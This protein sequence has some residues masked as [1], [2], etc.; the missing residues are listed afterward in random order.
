LF[1]A[2]DYSKDCGVHI[3]NIQ[4]ALVLEAFEMGETKTRSGLYQKNVVVLTQ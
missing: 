2:Y 4:N 1:D 3:N